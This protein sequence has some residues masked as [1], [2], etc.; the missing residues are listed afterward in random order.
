MPPR[1]FYRDKLSCVLRFVWSKRCHATC[2][3]IYSKNPLNPKKGKGNP[4]KGSG[5]VTKNG[6]ASVGGNQGFVSIKSIW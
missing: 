5:A 6:R 1:D 3:I 2:Q 4:K